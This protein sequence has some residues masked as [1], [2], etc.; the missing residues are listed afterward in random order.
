MLYTQEGKLEDDYDNVTLSS[1]TTQKV[2]LIAGTDRVIMYPVIFLID[3]K[4]AINLISPEL[5]CPHQ[6][7]LIPRHQ[8]PRL[9]SANKQSFGINRTNLLHSRVDNLYVRAWFRDVHNLIGALIFG[10]GFIDRFTWSFSLLE[11]KLIPCRSF[12]VAT[13]RTCKVKVVNVN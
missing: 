4:D 13:L 3:T 5:I 6:S 1:S 10:T 11:H 8:V 12:P 9:L 7:R 2:R